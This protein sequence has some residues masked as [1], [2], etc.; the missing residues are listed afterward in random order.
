MYSRIKM[1]FFKGIHL[2]NPLKQMPKHISYL[3]SCLV[4]CCGSTSLCLLVAN[5]NWLGRLEL[6]VKLHPVTAKQVGVID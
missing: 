1:C 6:G 2:N 5:T 4:L 3:C